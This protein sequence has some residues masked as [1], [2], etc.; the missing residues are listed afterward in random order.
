MTIATPDMN[1]QVDKKKKESPPSSLFHPMIDE[2]SI[3]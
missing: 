2:N 3:L 1:E